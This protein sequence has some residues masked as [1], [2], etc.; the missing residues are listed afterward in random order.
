MITIK[1]EGGL[2]NRMR[3]IDS[4]LLIAKSEG[5]TINVIWEM[6]FE[7]NCSFSKLFRFPDA[8]NLTERK[9]NRLFKSLK[10][11]LY[12]SLRKTG[13][14]LPL[15]YDIHLFDDEI[16]D[17]KRRN[18]DFRQLMG[19]DKS[20]YI[21]T[22]NQFFQGP[23]SFKAFIPVPEIQQIID[24][25]VKGFNS[26]TIGVH[27]RR[28]DNLRSIKHSPLEGFVALMEKEVNNNPETLFFLA[29]DS[30]EV[31]NTLLEIFKGRIITHKKMLD[32]NTEAGIQDA[33]IDLFCLSKTRKI[34][35]SH[36]SSYSEVAAQINNIELI[37]V[38]Q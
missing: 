12:R 34:F 32:R 19:P 2:G 36:Y 24:S 14:H 5:K 26:N 15:G 37:Q 6:T 28:K 38:L 9:I 4:A 13:V 10:G 7:L 21:N 35:G 11:L 33:L 29:T 22:C 20:V 1:P 27:I 23:E 25:Y 30:E 31:E 18:V 8:V 16:L 17:L 3:A